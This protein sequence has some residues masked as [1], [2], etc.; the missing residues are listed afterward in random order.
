MSTEVTFGFSG[1]T[2]WA[3]DS[4]LGSSRLTYFDRDGRLLHTATAAGSHIELHSSAVRSWIVP[5]VRGTDGLFVGDVGSGTEVL[6][7]PAAR[8]E[9]PKSSIRI[10][11]VRFDA[12]GRVVDTAGF[13]DSHFQSSATEV[14]SVGSST[15]AVPAPPSDVPP[16]KRT[17]RSCAAG[18]LPRLGDATGRLTVRE[19]R[20]R[21]CTWLAPPRRRTPS[22]ESP[23]PGL[24]PPG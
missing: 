10:P 24:E 22:P 1:D 11:R 20:R 12:Q 21:R 3:I 19:R 18:S 5:L 4:Y 17:Q 13:Y 6:M 15:Y 16:Q 14:L 23:S 7:S 9:R 8:T 2:I